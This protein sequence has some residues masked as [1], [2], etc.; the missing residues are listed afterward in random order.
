MR[1]RLPDHAPQVS[2]RYLYRGRSRSSSWGASAV[3]SRLLR[4]CNDLGVDATTGFEPERHGF[5]FGNR[6][7][8]K[9][10]VHELVEQRR[11][12]ELVGVD[13]PDKLEDLVG[14][15]READFWGPFGLCGGMSWASLDRFNRDQESPPDRSVP[16]RGTELFKELVTRQADSMDGSRMMTTCVKRQLLPTKQEWWRPWRETLGRVTE[17]KE[18]PRARASIDNGIPATLCLIR[19]H[20]FS[21]PSKHHQVL[22]I[23][24]SVDASK[25]L[26]IRL[27]DPNRPDREPELRARLGTRSHDLD[28]T[29]STGEKLYG[30]WVAKY[31]PA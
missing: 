10:V 11:L 18:W 24:Y 2:Q 4:L 9:D 19:A 15:V 14:R 27:Y 22:G 20:G 25:R 13:L 3:R 7:G 16:E 26:T 6:F 5:H 29:Q 21:D 17:L 31:R 1:T 30:F 23:G 28:L 12:D 8:G